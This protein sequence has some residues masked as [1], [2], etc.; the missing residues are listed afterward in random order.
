[1]LIENNLRI[2]R[3]NKDRSRER[4]FQTFFFFYKIEK[5]VALIKRLMV[6]VLNLS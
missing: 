6:R 5:I 3:G 2:F 4:I 1:M